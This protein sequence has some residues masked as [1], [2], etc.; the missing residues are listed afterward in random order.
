MCNLYEARFL[1]SRGLGNVCFYKFTHFAWENKWHCNCRGEREREGRIEYR[2]T[3]IWKS[4]YANVFL[5]IRV[6]WMTVGQ[7]CQPIPWDIVWLGRITLGKTWCVS[8]GK[9]TPSG[10][11][12]WTWELK[13]QGWVVTVQYPSFAVMVPFTRKGATHLESFNWGTTSD[14]RQQGCQQN[15]DRKCRWAD[16][17]PFV[18]VCQWYMTDHFGWTTRPCVQVDVAT[19]KRFIEFE[20]PMILPKTWEVLPSHFAGDVFTPD[21]WPF[22]RHRM[23]HKSPLLMVAGVIALGLLLG[24]FKH[25]EVL[26]VLKLRLRFL[27]I[28]TVGIHHILVGDC[29]FFR[30]IQVIC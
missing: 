4:L 11:D 12:F 14:K 13:L 28:N 2:W 17:Q 25:P 6:A 23:L 19:S 10:N 21:W 18:H 16:N 15:G 24:C 8:Y 22:L 3:Y 9:Q 27:K 5:A 30:C 1:S 26:P 7:P 29:I 20:S